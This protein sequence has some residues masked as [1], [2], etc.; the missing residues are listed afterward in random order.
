MVMLMMCVAV[1]G[2]ISTIPV[3]GCV[4]LISFWPRVSGKVWCSQGLSKDSI[5]QTE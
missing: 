1:V 4:L 5:R 3:P 2:L